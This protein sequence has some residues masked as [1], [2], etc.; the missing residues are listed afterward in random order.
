MMR[1]SGR[2]TKELLGASYLEGG[3]CF[4]DAEALGTFIRDSLADPVRE[5]S[6]S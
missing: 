2:L 4:T 6:L 1:V 3:P 5:R